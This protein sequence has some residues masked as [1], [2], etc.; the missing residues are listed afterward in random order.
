MDRRVLYNLHWKAWASCI[1]SDHNHIKQTYITL[2]TYL[3][4]SIVRCTVRFLSLEA[5]IF[6]LGSFTG[7]NWKGRE[8][9]GRDGNAWVGIP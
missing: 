5:F 2:P 4:T 1:G 9:T 6:F 7:A 3:P 8:G